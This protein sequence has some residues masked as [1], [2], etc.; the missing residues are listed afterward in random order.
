MLEPEDTGERRY[1]SQDR[2]ELV[3]VRAR[4]RRKQERLE[5]GEEGASRG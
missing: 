3:E 4:R 2:K 5:P 1:Y